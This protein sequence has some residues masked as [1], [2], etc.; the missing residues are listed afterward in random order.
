MFQKTSEF[1]QHSVFQQDEAQFPFRKQIES[2]FQTS[3]LEHIH[4]SEEQKNSDNLQDIETNQ[5]KKFQESIKKDNKFKEI[6]CSFL[7]SIQKTFFPDEEIMIY[8]SF[9][10][11]R[12]QFHNNKV[13]PPH[14]DSDSLGNHPLGEKNFLIPITRMQGTNRLFIES[15]PGK[16]DQQGITM[17]QGQFFFFNGNQCI[18]QNEK[19]IESD[20]R[21]SFDFRCILLKDYI[22]QIKKG[23]I[24]NTN[25]RDPEK[26]RV[27]TKMIIGGYYQ[28]H[29]VNDSFDTILQWHT[30]KD[31]LL[32]SQPNF[33]EEEAN[34]CQE[35][36][37]PGT[38]FVTEF[39]QTAT[40]EDMICQ[41]TGAKYCIMT[42]SGNMALILALMALNLPP[43]S[44]V[45]VPNQTMIA[46]I[47]S[48]QMIGLKPVLVDVNPESL[49]LSLT[50]IKSVLTENTSA[51]LHVS[52]NNRH[53]NI[54]DIAN[55]CEKS[56]IILIEDAAQSLGC[57]TLNQH[58]GTF[59]KIGCF[60]LSTPKIISTGQGG[61][62]I[63]ND[64][65]LAK[66]M[67][68]IKNFG[69]KSGGIDDFEV[70]GINMKF[71]DIQAVI[72]IEQMKKLPVRVKRLREM[73]DIYY[74]ELH[75]VCSMIPP[76]DDTWIPWFVDCFVDSR[77]SLIEWL[78]NHN[79]QTRPTY[80]EINKTPMY[81]QEKVFPI[82]EMVSKK[83]LFL[84][85]HTLLTD[86]QIYHICKLI[87]IFYSSYK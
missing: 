68:M 39:K 10:S 31:L 64:S 32:Q 70:F 17:N 46:S 13:I 80:P 9:P 76:K 36:M 47:N 21:I 27:P 45:I 33:G 8:Q 2:V 71:T 37:K 69:R 73:F 56:G 59:G 66:K 35:Y 86:A 51:I 72:G 60:S 30:Q 22:E 79:I 29:F 3:N 52:L 58:F 4:L 53:S 28:A 62:C 42:T 14:A 18:H 83:G 16:Q 84:P 43:G 50:E 44:E 49:T 63:T 48:I 7:K 61:F 65:S 82:S 85:S 24:V 1:G 19:N 74:K 38:N 81:Y 41:T 34:A 78:K 26:T 75:N 6:Y 87:R 11:I 55:F 12:I 5:H 54:K 67:N 20:I 40:L 25:P 77:D 23:H 15:E 57:F